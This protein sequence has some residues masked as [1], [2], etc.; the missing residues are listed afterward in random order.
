M[1]LRC[2]NN[3]ALTN[4]SDPIWIY[5]VY[6]YRPLP[7][8]P[9]RPWKVR[10]IVNNFIFGPLLPPFPSLHHPT[11]A[12]RCTLRIDRA[13]RMPIGCLQSN[14]MTNPSLQDLDGKWY[15]AWSTDGCNATTKK[16]FLAW[17]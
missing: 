8:D 12:V 16:A 2:A 3:A 13:Y 14:V 5:P 9:V 17:A 7:Y 6:Y 10:V 15:S 11:R 1:E 4:W